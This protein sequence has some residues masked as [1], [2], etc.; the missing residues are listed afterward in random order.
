MLERW[1]ERDWKR[2]GERET[3]L[4]KEKEKEET[5]RQQGRHNEV[6]VRESDRW[7]ERPGHVH[8]F[9]SSTWLW[10]W[11][12]SAPL[13]WS[14]E[15]VSAETP[16]LF[17]HSI[18]ITCFFMTC[19]KLNADSLHLEFHPGA[20]DPTA[21][22]SVDDDNCWHLDEEQVQEQVKLFLSQGGYH[23]SG[24]QLNLLFSKVTTSPARN[25]AWV[26]PHPG[27]VYSVDCGRFLVTF[28]HYVCPVSSGERDAEDEGLQRRPHVNADHRTV[29]GRSQTGAVEATGNHHDWQVQTAV[30][31]TRYTSL[32]V[33][34]CITFT[35]V[36]WEIVKVCV[37]CQCPPW[38][39]RTENQVMVVT[40]KGRLQIV[41]L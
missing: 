20:P 11:P 29:H 36:S 24:K 3:K 27:A 22:A 8:G 31:W 6:G 41:L 21:G 30:G 13:H 38:V 40:G 37:T 26:I 14:H 19:S 18:K 9:L 25:Q 23:G 12:S 4:M 16:S 1:R 2:E 33:T 7:K 28:T 15:H 34:V 10:P 32:T 35:A 5:E 39:Q 17:H